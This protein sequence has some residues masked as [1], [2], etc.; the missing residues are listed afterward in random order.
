MIGERSKELLGKA[1]AALKKGTS[2]FE[3]WFLSKHEVTLDECMT[4]SER[5]AALIEWFLDQSKKVQ[6]EVLFHDLG[7][8]LAE[9][10]ATHLAFEGALQAVDKFLEEQELL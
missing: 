8:P 2:P 1:A 6:I 5:M 7:S 3:H 10:L 9:E 4:M